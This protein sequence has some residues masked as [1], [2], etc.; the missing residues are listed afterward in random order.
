MRL[1]QAI[2][3]AK[4]IAHAPCVTRKCQI[5][6]WQ[7]ANWLNELKSRRNYE[8]KTKAKFQNKA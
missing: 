4:A 5:E 6:H 2:A 3:H 7:L 8:N 1:E